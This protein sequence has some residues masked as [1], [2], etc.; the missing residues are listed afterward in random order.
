MND[1][2]AK[3]ILTA[4]PVF[5]EEIEWAFY[6][7]WHHEGRRARMGAMMMGPDYAWWHGFYDLKRTYQHIV[8]LAE[9]ARAAGHGFATFVPGA[10]GPNL[11]TAPVAP[12][13]QA[14]DQVKELRGRPRKGR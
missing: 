6:E 13:P 7:F 9:Q 5:D 12:L 2:K 3:S 4:W 1:L 8:E 10:G 11:T 14:W